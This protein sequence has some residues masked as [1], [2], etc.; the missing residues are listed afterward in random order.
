MA[1]H[2]HVR[3][4][5]VQSTVGLLAAVPTALVHALDLL[6]SPA[7]A[8]VL[9][10]TRNGDER[11]NLSRVSTAPKPD[12]LQRGKNKRLG[13][14]KRVGIVTGNPDSRSFAFVPRSPLSS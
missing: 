12:K 13:G 7:G 6:V 10:G 4:Q 11:V 8:L 5:M 3:V 14:K 9:L 1:L 2:R